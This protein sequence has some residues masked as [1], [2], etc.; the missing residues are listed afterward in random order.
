MGPLTLY[1][2]PKYFILILLRV[3]CQIQTAIGSFGWTSEHF[4][5]WYIEVTEV[6]T[7]ST[8]A[9]D[10]ILALTFSH[11]DS[12]RQTE[13]PEILS[14]LIFLLLADLTMQLFL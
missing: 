4:L 9:E 3:N 6:S 14:Q 13:K 1:D 8:H 11:F 2:L 5:H 10:I 7:Y 12:L